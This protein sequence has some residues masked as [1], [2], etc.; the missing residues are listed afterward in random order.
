MTLGF[1]ATNSDT[2]LLLHSTQLLFKVWV[3]V[4][5][6]LTL[7]YGELVM[8]TTTVSTLQTLFDN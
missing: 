5:N 2:L 6:N 7:T 1:F 8:K 3:K 4:L